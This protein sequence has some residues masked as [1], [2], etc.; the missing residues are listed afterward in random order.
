M[1]LPKDPFI[2]LSVIN[3][4]LRDGGIDLDDYC[5][6]KNVNKKELLS[7]MRGAGFEYDSD[8]RC[9]R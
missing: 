7:M 3:T 4:A 9:F 8:R 6:E 1:N 2:V 5:A